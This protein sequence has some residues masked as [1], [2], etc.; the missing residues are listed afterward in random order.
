MKTD[1]HIHSWYSPDAINSPRAICS[2][3]LHKG[4]GAIA[5]TDH[6]TAAGWGEMRYE[7]EI[8]DLLFVPG[9]EQ[10][11]VCAG[12]VVGEILCLFLMEPIVSHDV[13]GILREVEDQ[14]G[15]AA[16]AHPFDRRR[17]ALGESGMVDPNTNMGIEILNG[18]SYRQVAND[19]AA[20]F[21][22]QFGLPHVGGSDAHTPYEVGNVYVEGN[23]SSVT[24][25]RDDIRQRRVRIAG[26]PS[27]PVFSLLSGLRKVGMGGR[28]TSPSIDTD[29]VMHKEP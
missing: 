26:H 11:V 3:A 27:H 23:A 6:N 22:R 10:T 25:L 7:A 1:L 17:P 15:I 28:K 13:D 2:A 5:L 16:A 24:D 20:A 8:A 12:E 18:R 9:Q 19:R 29:G 4:L 21:S 14:G